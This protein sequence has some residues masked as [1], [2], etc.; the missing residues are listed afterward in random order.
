M[1]YA[2]ILLEAIERETH[3]EPQLGKLITALRLEAR[4]INICCIS[5]HHWIMIFGRHT[6]HCHKGQV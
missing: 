6:F 4:N 3:K 5:V 1:Y 2:G